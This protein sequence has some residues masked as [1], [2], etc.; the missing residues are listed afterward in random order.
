MHKV[1]LFIVIPVFNRL[2]FTINCLKS[3]EAQSYQN[4]T[5]ILVDDGS[6]DGTTAFVRG[7]F[8]RVIVLETTGDLFWTKSINIGIKYALQNKAD[9]VLTLNN[10]TICPPEFL[11]K[12]MDWAGQKP[13]ALLGALAVDSGTGKIVYG[14]EVL[15][16]ASNTKK[17][18]KN[19]LPLEQ[20]KGIHPSTIF[21]GRGLLIPKIVFDKIGLFEEELLPHYYADYDFTAKAVRKGFSLYCNYDAKLLTYPEESG[22]RNIR[23]NKSFKNYFNHLFGIKGGGNLKNFTY[24]AVRNCPPL[25]L[26]YFL[27]N[28]YIRRIF[29]YLIK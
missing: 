5:V 3:L 14:G 7:N 29:G 22:D 8:P 2:N 16:W 18:L 27:L 11:E 15:Y 23:K 1:D 21:P 19:T 4:H 26:P 24:F 25:Y 10:D 17:I 6:T 20:Q 9:Y 28:G 12:M 13:E